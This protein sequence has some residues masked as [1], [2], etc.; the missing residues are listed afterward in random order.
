VYEDL[1]RRDGSITFVPARGAARVLTKRLEAC[2]SQAT[3]PHLGFSLREIADSL[4]DLLAE[5][6]RA[7]G[8]GP[9]AIQVRDAAPL[10]GSPALPNASASP[11]GEFAAGGGGTN[12]RN[13]F[14]GT[15]ECFDTAP[16]YAAGNTRTYHPNQYF[17]ELQG[18]AP[19]APPA[20]GHANLRERWE[21]LL[22]GCMPAVHTIFPIE[23]D[24]C[25]DMLVFGG[26][27]TTRKF[28][29]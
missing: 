26:V 8:G 1:S 23:G 20:A 11:G 27:E 17:V 25:L 14:V 4:H 9:D 28:I 3:V 29:V 24:S 18:A 6:L 7:G 21:G 22:S 10:I 13:T 12:S 16:V 2:Y 5:R 19:G 15:K